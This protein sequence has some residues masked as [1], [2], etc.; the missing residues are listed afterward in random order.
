[1]KDP[2]ESR[3]EYDPKNIGINPPLIILIAGTTLT[4]KSTFG[5]FLY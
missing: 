2:D 4:G 3:Y 1:M 5:K